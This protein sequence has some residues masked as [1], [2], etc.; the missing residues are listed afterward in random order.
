[1][2]KGPKILVIGAGLI[3]LSTAYA[4]KN[5]GADVTIV[6]ARPN[7]M[8]G[9]SYS[10]SGM[11]HISQSRAWVGM[12]NPEDSF[13]PTLSVLSLAKESRKILK[14]NLQS[15]NLTDILSRRDGGYQIFTDSRALENAQK[16]YD[17]LG[18]ETKPV[19]HPV[20][21]FGHKGLHFPKDGSGDAFEY[22]RAVAKYLEAQGVLFIYGASDLRLRSGARGVTAQLRGHIFHSDH[23]VVC[24][25]PHTP[26]VLEPLGLS[27]R[28]KNV[29]GFA[30]NFQRP[31]RVLPN[32]PVMDAQSRSA[33][34]ILGDTLRLS[35][36]VGEISAHPLLKRWFQLAPA[37]MS[38]LSP[39]KEVWS[40]L[41][42]MSPAGRP[43]ISETPLPNFW[44]NTGHG[45][46]GWT[47]CAGS[48]VLMS[49]MIL[50]GKTDLR[51]A[52][53]R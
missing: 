27:L 53:P 37:M 13:K 48:G 26:R 11:L 14:R 36:T 40:G 7:A 25:G 50:Q 46:M 3:G 12:D 44:V 49:D 17:A 21:T 2:A 18:V 38:A 6:D 35:G 4:L 22:G 47:L 32:V 45:H 20:N 1:M 23:I 9:T 43:Y 24:A 51:F 42:P 15:L 30:V 34:T 31:D 39:A 10:N 8:L 5:K 16:N 28:L 19:S 29:R 52:Y 33:L 41:R